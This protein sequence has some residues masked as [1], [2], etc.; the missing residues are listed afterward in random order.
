MRI[1]TH[2]QPRNL[3][4]IGILLSLHISRTVLQV[5]F[6]ANVDGSRTALRG[7]NSMP[8]AVAAGA[9]WACDEEVTAAGVK[10][11]GERLRGRADSERPL[12]ELAVVVI[13]Q[14]NYTRSRATNKS[15]V[16]WV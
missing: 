15:P 4:C 2:R 3:H 13:S 16:V 7:V 9:R 10:L 14:G 11:D 5:E 6:L 12:P 1:F 8:F